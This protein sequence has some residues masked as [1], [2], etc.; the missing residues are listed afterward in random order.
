M[1]TQTYEVAHLRE[2]GQDMIIVPVKS[3]VASKTQQ[4]QNEIKSSL[5]MYAEN[6]GLAGTVCLVWST[7]NR[8]GFLAPTPWHGFFRSI[9]MNFVALNVNKKLT[10][11]V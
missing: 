6:A 7:G 5:Q 4:Q 2:Q 11:S 9:N 3:S 8:F 10:C 1:S